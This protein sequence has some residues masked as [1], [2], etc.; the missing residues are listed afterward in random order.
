MADDGGVA[1]FLRHLDRVEGLGERAD[2]IYFHQDRVRRA[3]LDAA[4]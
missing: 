4:A 1:G 2:L 3:G